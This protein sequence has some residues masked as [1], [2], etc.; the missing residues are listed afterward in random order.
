[1]FGATDAVA[2]A[3]PETEES[4]N[5]E[6]QSDG[7]P[8]I[9]A[10]SMETADEMNVGNDSPQPY[11]DPTHGARVPQTLP[12][13]RLPTPP[14]DLVARF[15]QRGAAATAAAAA[16]DVEAPGLADAS[17]APEEPAAFVPWTY[18]EASAASVTDAETQTGETQTAEPVG[19][20]NAPWVA[21]DT[22]AAQANGWTSE[23]VDVQVDTSAEHAGAGD[24]ADWSD[25]A[26]IAGPVAAAEWPDTTATDQVTVQ[27]AE[28]SADEAAAP[29]ESDQ[30]SEVAVD[31]YEAAAIEAVG[32]SSGEELANTE[33]VG[34][35]A[36]PVASAAVA[37]GLVD[38]IGGADEGT[39]SAD[40]SHDQAAEAELDN[41]HAVAADDGRRD[42]LGWAVLGAAATSDDR[43]APPTETHEWRADDEWPEATAYGAAPANGDH[44]HAA[45]QDAPEPQEAAAAE[46]E[47]AEPVTAETLPDE[48]HPAGADAAVADAATA[49]A[50]AADG[51]PAHA[52]AA[53]S[54]EPA[55]ADAEPEAAEV[56]ASTPT[57]PQ[58]ESGAADVH[59]W[60]MPEAVD[61]E[62]A[63]SDAWSTPAGSK[64]WK[65]SESAAAA[66]AVAATGAGRRAA[67]GG[68]VDLDVNRRLPRHVREPA[69][70][71]G[72]G[73]HH[74][75]QPHGER[76]LQPLRH[77][78]CPD[79][80]CCRGC[81]GATTTSPRGESDLWH[82]VSE[83][84][85][86]AP[87]T[88]EKRSFD[89]VTI[90]LTVLVAIIIVA[91]LLGLL[92]TVAPM[93]T[94]AAH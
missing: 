58:P 79:S 17:S 16:T 83:P 77:L 57:E 66:A 86:T 59:V 8:T 94:G 6:G 11:V 46:H 67:I 12:D 91:L 19:T 62:A 34:Y 89:P 7:E 44:E 92:Y 52:A 24:A 38:G 51:A 60:P 70:R 39:A 71:P 29:A 76:P 47:P 36:T 72:R 9:G 5:L 3:A 37:A 93:L 40:E 75:E 88:S 13:D 74:L 35:D 33:F 50:A 2:E 78:A 48:P 84:A 14:P 82:L 61:W 41:S 31:W 87:T 26:S 81:L 43:E 20:E 32:T 18:E 80:E 45:T 1:M 21:A 90:F 28:A 49:D 69:R 68:R 63:D 64:P 53:V 23:P 55:T 25:W 4:L 27:P 15:A 65:D 10:E 30:A 42:A 56:A 85:A 54:T 73:V 22:D